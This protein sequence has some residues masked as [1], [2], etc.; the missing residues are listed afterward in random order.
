MAAIAQ[1]GFF[2]SR[3]GSSL[4]DYRFACGY[5]SPESADGSL[6]ETALT[7]DQVPPGTDDA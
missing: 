7:E 3:R 4:L 1:E 2:T 6:C 5:W